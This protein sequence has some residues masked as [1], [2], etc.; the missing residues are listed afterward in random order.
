MISKI[1][2]QVLPTRVTSG[3]LVL[4]ILFIHFLLQLE[5]SPADYILVPQTRLGFQ[6]EKESK[7]SK[8]AFDP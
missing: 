2:P 4:D 6:V 1:K 7:Q 5:P 8:M 3:E